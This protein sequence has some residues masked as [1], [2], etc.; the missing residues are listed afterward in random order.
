MAIGRFT[1]RNAA[2]VNRRPQQAAHDAHVVAWIWSERRAYD[3][4]YLAAI[5]GKVVC[6]GG[7]A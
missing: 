3:A 7:A 6:K 1:K 2:A 5:N 4:G